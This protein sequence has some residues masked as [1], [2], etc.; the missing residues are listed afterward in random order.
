VHELLSPQWLSGHVTIV[1]K[2]EP[3]TLFACSVKKNI[4]FGLERTDDKPVIEDIQL[5]WLANAQDF[6][7]KLPFGYDTECGE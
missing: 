2:Q 7:V 5:A 6:I 3:T 4:M 1:P